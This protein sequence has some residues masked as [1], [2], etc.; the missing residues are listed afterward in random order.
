[1]LAGVISQKTI[2]KKP[3][4][5][6]KGHEINVSVNGICHQQNTFD[7]KNLQT[8]MTNQIY[9]IKLINFLYLTLLKAEFG[10]HLVQ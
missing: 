6:F 5:I 1:M 4:T 3:A 8:Q 10:C 2:Q 9:I 7:S